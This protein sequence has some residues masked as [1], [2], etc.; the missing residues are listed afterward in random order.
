MSY[1]ALIA[2]AR[3]AMTRQNIPKYISMKL[4]TIMMDK[5]YG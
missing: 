3:I 4:K 5:E 1:L 2:M